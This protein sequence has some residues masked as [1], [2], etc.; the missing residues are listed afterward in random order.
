MAPL[1]N[2]LSES[3]SVLYAFVSLLHHFCFSSLVWLGKA[4]K[5]TTKPW[6]REPAWKTQKFLPPGFKLPHLQLLQSLWG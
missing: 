1:A 2:A 4:V 5:D 3:T 6:C